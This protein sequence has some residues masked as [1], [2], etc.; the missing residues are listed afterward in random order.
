MKLS[1]SLLSSAFLLSA[2][3][4]VTG[5]RLHP[6][7][8]LKKSD[9][10]SSA[11]LRALKKEKKN[12]CRPAKVDLEDYSVWSQTSG[13]WVEIRQYS[14]AS[15]E[16][17]YSEVILEKTEVEG[18]EITIKTFYG[19]ENWTYFDSFTVTSL[20]CNKRKKKQKNGIVSNG[21]GDASR[22][23][24]DF[25]AWNSTQYYED[26][27]DIEFYGNPQVSKNDDKLNLE[28][29]I[30]ENYYYESR[31]VSFYDGDSLGIDFFAGNVN[32]TKS[33]TGLINYYGDT[34]FYHGVGYKIDNEDELPFVVSLYLY[35]LL[36]EVNPVTCGQVP[37]PE[38]DFYKFFYDFFEISVP[39]S[40]GIDDD[41]I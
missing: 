15:M 13:Y 12:K 14:S 23:S 31:T 41:P 36:C 9:L 35:F 28:V 21:D 26:Q 22:I 4:N 30:P 8:N 10:D 19:G 20:T 5:V 2:L 7:K 29:S 39:P 40:I 18:N 17:S 37:H 3:S 27:Y 38:N 16:Y 25:A 24:G 34:D 6:S 11:A 1:S 33:L 32:T